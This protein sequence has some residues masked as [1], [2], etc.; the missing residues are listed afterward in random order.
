MKRERII[1][2]PPTA[3]S[4]LD[5]IRLKGERPSRPDARRPW[6]TKPGRSAR[7]W[8]EVLRPRL[9]ASRPLLSERHGVATLGA[10][11]FRNVI[12]ET[13]AHV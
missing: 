4:T 1:Q 7:E 10:P 3:N 6:D 2:A 8:F 9:I 12:D 5:G 13:G 11:T